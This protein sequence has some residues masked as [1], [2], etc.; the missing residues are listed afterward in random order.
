MLDL[1]LLG[2]Q[3]RGQFQPDVRELLAHLGEYRVAVLLKFL[4]KRIDIGLVQWYL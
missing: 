2:L 4:A 3:F 1:H